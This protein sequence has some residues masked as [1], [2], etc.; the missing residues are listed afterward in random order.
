MSIEL[1]EGTE[2]LL[3]GRRCPRCFRAQERVRRQMAY[4]G[5]RGNVILY[6]CWECK[7]PISCAIEERRKGNEDAG[8]NA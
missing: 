2:H 5:E 4:Q 7:R 1:V 3:S 8:A 6:S